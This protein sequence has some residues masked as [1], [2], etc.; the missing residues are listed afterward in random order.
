MP[1]SSTKTIRTTAPYAHVIDRL[2][3]TAFGRLIHKHLEDTTI[4][5]AA[6]KLVHDHM[7]KTLTIVNNN[8]ARRMLDAKRKLVTEVPFE[9]ELNSL[10]TWN[11]EYSQVPIYYH[12][13]KK[14]IFTSMPARKEL[15]EEEKAAVKVRRAEHAARTPE[16]REIYKAAQKIVRAA[17]AAA[18]RAA[19]KAALV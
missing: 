12:K 10:A 9:S 18:T 6:V 16:E 17:K 11:K 15:T 4:E 7:D 1:K 8:V 3:P 13:G 5:A 2:N 14:Q 19:K